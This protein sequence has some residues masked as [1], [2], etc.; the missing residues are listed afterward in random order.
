MELEILEIDEL[1]KLLDDVEI[2]LVLVPSELNAAI[3]VG[4]LELAELKDVAATEF[5]LLEDGGLLLLGTLDKLELL[6][7]PE[8]SPPTLPPPPHAE[9]IN[10]TNKNG[11]ISLLNAIDSFAFCIL[12]CIYNA[13][14]NYSREIWD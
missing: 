1:D 6:K 7:L 5:L 4:A 13:N 9:F 10:T 14:V 3:E 8:V 11:A 12:Y 2:A